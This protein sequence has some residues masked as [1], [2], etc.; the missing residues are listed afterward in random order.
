LPTSRCAGATGARHAQARAPGRRGRGR[1][2]RLL[3]DDPRT[4]SNPERL[5]RRLASEAGLP[6]PQV[7]V[8]ILG[9][10]RDFAWPP[11]RLAVEVDGHA[12]HA[13]RG[14][15][16]VDHARDAELVLAGWRVL[17]FTADQLEHERAAVVGRLRHAATVGVGRRASDP[18]ETSHAG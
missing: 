16:E 5:L 3:G 2:A 13:P 9:H 15:R 10:E 4:R 18:A 17:R 1:L 12:F 8:R 11:L 6:E 7:N 14:A